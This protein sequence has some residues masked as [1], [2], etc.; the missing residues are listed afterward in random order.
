MVSTEEMQEYGTYIA[1][2]S[3]LFIPPNLIFPWALAGVVHNFESSSTSHICDSIRS[4]KIEG[5]I[6]KQDK[7]IKWKINA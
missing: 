2:L 6:T 7:L 3:I 5:D 1:C 4:I